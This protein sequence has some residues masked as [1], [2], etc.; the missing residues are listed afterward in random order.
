MVDIGVDSLA[1]LVSVVV[2][3]DSANEVVEELTVVVVVVEL[4]VVVVLEPWVDKAVDMI[5]VVGS[6]V[7]EDGIV[8]LDDKVVVTVVVFGV[9]VGVELI[10]LVVVI[11]AGR[12]D[13]VVLL[14]NG[15]RVIDELV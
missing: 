5:S 14:V 15:L 3:V 2:V 12:S 13:F 8:V 9:G 10:D 11:L 7:V 4:R 6:D 1:G